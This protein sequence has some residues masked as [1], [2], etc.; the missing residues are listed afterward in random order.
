MLQGLFVTTANRVVAASWGGWLRMTPPSRYLTARTLLFKAF[1]VSALCQ[2]EDAVE[3]DIAIG[4]LIIQAPNNRLFKLGNQPAPNATSFSSNADLQGRPC[5][6][7]HPIGSLQLTN[8]A[9]SALPSLKSGSRSLFSGSARFLFQE[10]LSPGLSFPLQP[11]SF[12]TYPFLAPLNHHPTPPNSKIK[13]LHARESR[14]KRRRSYRLFLVTKVRRKR[15]KALFLTS[16]G[17]LY[18]RVVNWCHNCW[19]EELVPCNRALDRQLTFFELDS[20]LFFALR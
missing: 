6:P 11:Y 2:W 20:C 15:S 9:P 16:C 13:C 4:Q 3:R 8:L 12:S 18:V 14:R 10:E 5:Q 19:C 1:R 7:F 17:A